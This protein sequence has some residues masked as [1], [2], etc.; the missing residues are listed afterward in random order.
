MEKINIENKENNINNDYIIKFCENIIQLYN[1][2]EKKN[3]FDIVI[4]KFNKFIL[5]NFNENKNFVLNDENFIKIYKYS[6]IIIIPLTIIS[7]DDNYYKIIY[8]KI[9]NNLKQFIFLSIKNILSNI[10]Y[11]SP[12]ITLFIKNN[13]NNKENNNKN[14][15]KIFQNFINSFFN[16][17]YKNNNIKNC[18]NQLIENLN[19]ISLDNLINIINDTILY[20]Y[21]NK[22][23]SKINYN[24]NEEEYK[25]LLIPSVPFIKSSLTKKYC[26]ALDMD[27]TISHNLIFDFGNYFI[28]RP[29]VINF[30][31]KISQYYEIIIFTSSMKSYADNILDKIDKE[32]KFFSYRL[33]NKHTDIIKGKTIKDISKIGRNLKQIVLVDNDK[34]NALYK[35]NFIHIKSWHYDLF[36]DEIEK[37]QNILIE[38]A[39]DNECDDIRNLLKKLKMMKKI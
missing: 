29:K 2:L 14:I 31:V 22:S 35:E 32:N 20:N 15:F 5:K 37:I 34:S 8:E 28:L 4:N 19:K 39:N 36:D 16:G 27:E 17:K 9:K 3:L 18:I 13:N 33:Y 38:I 26:L 6:C 11:K 30:L 24:N 23:N 21:D 25:K 10:N 12:Q 1:S 7:L